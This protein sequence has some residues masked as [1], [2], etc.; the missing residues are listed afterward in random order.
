MP[1]TP[2]P[3]S[4]SPAWPASPDDSSTP[5]GGPKTTS[6]TASTAPST[7]WT[8]HS[9]AFERKY[10]EAPEDF[11]PVPLDGVERRPG[12]WSPDGSEGAGWTDQQ[13]Q[14]PDVLFLYSQFAPKVRPSKRNGPHQ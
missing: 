8:T 2:S 9:S 13:R 7:G 14:P 3:T 4:A 6:R 11:D 10:T 12:S 5:T 1:P